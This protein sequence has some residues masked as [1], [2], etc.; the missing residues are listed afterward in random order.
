MQKKKSVSIVK[1]RESSHLE[2]SSLR[3][4]ESFRN[5]P[6][7][8]FKLN[9]QKEHKKDQYN[10]SLEKKSKIGDMFA[11]AHKANPVQQVCKAKHRLQDHRSPD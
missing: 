5:L 10:L 1:S 8:C 3:N 2:D 7:W 4:L 11:I 6:R 9:S